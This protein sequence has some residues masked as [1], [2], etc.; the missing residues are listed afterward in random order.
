MGTVLAQSDSMQTTVTCAA[1]AGVSADT[2]HVEVDLAMGLPAFTIVGL[3]EGAVKESKVRV[4]A[5]LSNCGYAVPPRKITVNL[6]PAD[7]KKSGSAFDL[8]IALGL[9]A[10]VGLLDPELLK[11]TM[12]VGELGLDGRCRPVPGALPYTLRARKDKCSQIIIAADNAAEASVVSQLD[13]LPVHDLPTAVMHLTGEKLIFSHPAIDISPSS[14]NS[15]IDMSE[16][17]G[18]E[19]VKR[20]LEV[21]AAGAHNA[22]MIGPPGSGKTMLARRLTTILPPLT[23]LSPMQ[24]WLVAPIHPDRARCHWLTMAFSF[25]MSFPSLSAT[26][27]RY[28]ANHWRK[29]P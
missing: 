17:R 19:H 20:A 25:S 22:I 11:K 12:V 10:G 7:L 1:L 27:S 21:A 23:T 26:C 16:V 4:L 2:V 3:P 5:A 29:G 28:C 9:L 18:Q 13:V 6:A 14:A 15:N 24:G 8:A